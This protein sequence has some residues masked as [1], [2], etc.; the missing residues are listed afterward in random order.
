MIH[1][2]SCTY[3]FE[4]ISETALSRTPTVYIKSIDLI[5][6]KDTILVLQDIDL[7]YNIEAF[8]YNNVQVNIMLDGKKIHASQYA[9]GTYRL[10]P[11]YNHMGFHELKLQVITNSGTNSLLDNLGGEKLMFERSWVVQMDNLPSDELIFKNFYYDEGVL[12]LQWERC[13]RK[14]FDVYKIYVMSV[15]G[16]EICNK[17]INIKDQNQ[18]SLDLSFYIGGKIT[19]AGSIISVNNNYDQKYVYTTHSEPKQ[20][21][22]TV[23]KEYNGS[24]SFKWAKPKYYKYLKNS[25]IHDNIYLNISDTIYYTEDV[26][27]NK[28]VF[29]NLPFGNIFYYIY[30]TQLPESEYAY[31]DGW[32]SWPYYSARSELFRGYRARSAGTVVPT[33]SPSIFYFVG[34]GNVLASNYSKDFYTSWINSTEIDLSSVPKS[35]FA[36]SDNGENIIIGSVEKLIK[37]TKGTYLREKTI[38]VAG[39]DLQYVNASRPRSIA[40]SNDGLLLIGTNTSVIASYD[41]TTNTQKDI[42]RT[43]SYGKIYDIRIA[44]NGTYAI[45]RENEAIIGATLINGE[46]SEVVNITVGNYPQ[47]YSNYFYT[48]EGN[49]VYKYNPST[50]TIIE[51]I[52][53]DEPIVSPVVDRI[54][55]NFAGVSSDNQAIIFNATGNII[56]QVPLTGDFYQN[57]PYWKDI[58]LNNNILYYNGFRLN[59]DQ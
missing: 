12:K 18:T 8:N 30:F 6:H 19:I 35:S 38:N 55:G 46:F 56:K 36:V 23:G 34:D 5:N 47:V 27:I 14:N 31:C 44:P 26:N 11:Y 51:T 40:V 20:N 2:S 41:L 59:V 3:E 54:T 49:K 32:Y 58:S 45:W 57:F 43:P 24:P 21:L 7:N 29:E 4:E 10:S 9:S 22:I 13:E 39:L 50:F 28:Y 42:Y 25:I 16:S 53:L 52:T 48:F 1:F 33:S 17:I 37:F 15:D